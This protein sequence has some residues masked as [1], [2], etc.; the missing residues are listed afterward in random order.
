MSASF[1]LTRDILET[2]CAGDCISYGKKYYR[3]VIATH[4]TYISGKTSLFKAAVSPITIDRPVGISTVTLTTNQTPVNSGE[5]F[6]LRVNVPGG[7]SWNSSYYAEYSVAIRALCPAGV[8]VNIAGT[9]CGQDLVLPLGTP[10]SLSQSIPTMITN[11]GWLSKDV[12]F[13][14]FVKNAFGQVVGTA[15][16]VVKVNG[17]PFSW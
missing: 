16:T 2:V 17:V 3:I 11:T 5:G 13:E 7:I 1:V 4:L 12:T 9:P 15:Q 14:L 6:R 10:V 8:A